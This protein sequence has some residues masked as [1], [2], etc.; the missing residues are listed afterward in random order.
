MRGRVG[1]VPDMGS[2]VRPQRLG[3][4]WLVLSILYLPFTRFTVLPAIAL[5]LINAAVHARHISMRRAPGTTPN[6]DRLFLLLSGGYATIITVLLEI[7]CTTL[8]IQWMYTS[9]THARAITVTILIDI[10]VYLFYEKNLIRLPRVSQFQE[11]ILPRLLRQATSTDEFALFRGY[12][13]VGSIVF[14]L[15][16]FV[17]MI[18]YFEYALKYHPH[19]SKLYADLRSQVSRQFSVWFSSSLQEEFLKWSPMSC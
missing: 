18:F 13:T 9:S 11:Y 7:T 10:Y 8:W 17:G 12:F 15:V 2:E 16:C 6:K 14:D 19:C 3:M 4:S 1:M 5:A